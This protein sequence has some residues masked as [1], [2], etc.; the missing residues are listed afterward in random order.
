MR[1]ACFEHSSAQRAQAIAQAWTTAR[2]TVASKAVWRVS[3]LPFASQTSAQSIEP[4]AADHLARR[5][6]GQAGVG[7]GRAGLRA[8]EAGL[9]AR[10]ELAAQAAIGLRMLGEHRRGVTHEWRRRGGS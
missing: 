6:L 5:G 8:V 2:A 9:D 1:A 3:T 4:D 7:A 10:E